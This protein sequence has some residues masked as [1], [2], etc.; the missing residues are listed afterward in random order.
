[1][2]LATVHSRAQN[3]IQAPAVQIESHLGGGLPS[4]SIVGLP[5]TAVKE[6]KDR[7]RAALQVSG[8]EF[9]QRRITVNLAPAD[10]PKTGGRFDLGIAIAILA[11]SGQ[12]NAGPLADHE[13]LGEL[14]LSGG[15]RPVR[16]ALSAA[17]AARAARR[18]LVLP[19]DN[20]AEA[21]LVDGTTV[22]PVSSLLD[23][24]AHLNGEAPL[25]A[26]T[27]A[28]PSSTSLSN[29]DIN[30]VRG[31]Y[32]AKRA[33]EIAAAGGHSLLMFGPPGTGKTML[34]TRLPGLLPPLSEAEAIETAAVASISDK[35][36]D[37]QRW[38]Q[39]P[40]RAPHHTAS[41]VALV[42]GGSTP[43]PGEVSLAHN[44]ILFL[45]ELPEFDRKVLEVLREPLE[46]GHITISRAAQQA[47]FPARFQLIAA[48]N[49]CP[50]G[51]DCSPEEEQRYRQRLSEPFLDRIDMMVELP[52]IDQH[53]LQKADRGEDSATVRDRVMGAHAIQ[54]ARQGTM[55]SRLGPRDVDT[56]CP[57]SPPEQQ[58]L[59]RAVERLGLSA[60]AYH[61]VLRLARTIADLGGAERIG[62]EALSEALT[63][64]RG[65]WRS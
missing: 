65:P 41:G 35:G 8:F 59:A 25:A 51:D 55:N 46:N 24:C 28:L 10:L 43:K 57:L 52:R 40:F 56:H 37:I 61:R 12:I 14:S 64:R 4:F 7:V 54:T 18:A 60:R 49:P 53:E 63:Y 17:L 30:E 50:R 26:T 1:M 13:F 19:G 23:L 31:Q 44:G 48:M 27:A 58:L 20:A 34:A 32:H 3:G 42:G 33:L 6:S 5:E 45:D 29:G 62:M 47:E 16:G 11:A 21:A 38:R 9:P 15:V 22:L 39:R 36:L 2:N